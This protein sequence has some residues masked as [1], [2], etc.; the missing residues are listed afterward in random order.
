MH[1]EAGE[2]SKTEGERKKSNKW[3][4]LYLGREERASFD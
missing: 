1:R 3:E 2:N 4:T